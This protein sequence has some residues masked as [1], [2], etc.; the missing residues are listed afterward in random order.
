MLVCHSCDNTSTKKDTL[1]MHKGVKH[2]AK[3]SNCDKCEYSRTQNEV[4]VMHNFR[5]YEGQEPPRKLCKL[6]DFTSDILN[7]Q[8]FT[9]PDFRLKKIY[10]KKSENFFKILIAKSCCNL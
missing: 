8:N 9:Q 2:K 5:K 1:R 4:P 7:V 10:T 6:C 3:L